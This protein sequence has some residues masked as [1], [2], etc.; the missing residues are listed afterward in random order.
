M[1]EQLRERFLRRTPQGRLDVV[2]TAQ[3]LFGESGSANELAPENYLA[4]LSEQDRAHVTSFLTYASALRT[5]L[6]GTDLA[7]TAVGSSV[8]SESERHH[9]VRDIDLR[10]LNSAP[11]KS[12]LRQHAVGFIKDSIR[13]YLQA[14]GVEFAEDD[15]TVSSRMVEGSSSGWQED[16]QT[17]ERK[18][19]EQKGLLPYVDWYNNDPSFTIGYPEGLPVQLSIS[20]VDNWD[21]NTYLRKERENNGHFVL[22]LG[23]K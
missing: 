20:G 2:A 7:V 15:A 17:G 19:V 5:S 14:A 22:L 21:L 1:L 9:P 13:T 4:S 8:R 11:P 6:N 10:I 3:N 12:E 23:A 18:W 16:P